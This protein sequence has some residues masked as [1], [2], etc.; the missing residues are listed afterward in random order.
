MTKS[1]IIGALIVITVLY[2]AICLLLYSFQEKLLFFPQKLD[3]DFKFSFNQPFEEIDIRT[4]DNISLHGILFK[5]DNPKGLI[6]YLHG[7]AGSLHSW[8]NVAELYTDMNYDVFILDYRGYGK[9]EGKIESQKQ[10]YQ[11]VQITYNNLKQRY[12][13][14][15]II[16][17]GYSIGTGLASFTASNNNPKLLILQSPYYSLTDMVRRH[18]PIIPSFILKYKFNNSKHISKCKMPIV[19]FHGDQD[20]VIYHG[21]S[22]KLKN[23]FSEKDTLI[24]LYGQK[25]NGMTF[26]PDYIKAIKKYLVNNR[27]K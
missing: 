12:Q 7:N 21:S 1:F 25:H 27:K 9:S 18:Y 26:N 16:I 14:D 10:I 4:S 2:L 13:E 19:I 24:T 3:K 17:L 6:F 22:I 5:T 15:N 23:H 20:E 8:G 11:D